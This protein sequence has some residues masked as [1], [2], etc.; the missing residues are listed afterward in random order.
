MCSEIRG[1][2]ERWNDFWD[3]MNTLEL[4]T[5]IGGEMDC[6]KYV[7]ELELTNVKAGY[8]GILYHE[9]NRYQESR[10]FRP[11]EASV[12]CGI[13]IVEENKVETNKKDTKLHW[14]MFGHLSKLEA[15][16]KAAELV[17]W[18]DYSWMNAV[19]W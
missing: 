17:A 4:Y 8:V 5:T 14:N 12:S 2:V 6:G 16:R 1:Q 19:R 13:Q 3:E 11:P 15:V 18:M 7:S 10:R 9:S